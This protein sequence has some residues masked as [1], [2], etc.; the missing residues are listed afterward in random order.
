MS[1]KAY[2][3]KHMCNKCEAL[4]GLKSGAKHCYESHVDFKD[5]EF[6]SC[7]YER[8]DR[9]PRCESVPFRI[10]LRDGDKLHRYERTAS[11]VQGKIVTAAME[12]AEE[13]APA[14]VHQAQ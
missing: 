7:V 6:S 13:H 1:E 14:R 5:M 8:P 4:H 3:T 10:T 2:S 11:Y 12:I 9:N